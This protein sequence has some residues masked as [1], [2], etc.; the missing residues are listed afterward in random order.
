VTHVVRTI[1][2]FWAALDLAL[3][4]GKEPS[5]HAFAAH[6]LPRAIVR[7]AAEWDALPPLIPGRSEYR[8]LIAAGVV[9]PVYAIEAQLAPDGAIE[10]VAIT[11]DT[12]SP[13]PPD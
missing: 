11:V 9:V 6:D 3:P 10:L 4:A 2:D 13:L 8:I 5:W 7:F 1:E 12:T